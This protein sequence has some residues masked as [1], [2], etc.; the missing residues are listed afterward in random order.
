MACLLENSTCVP[1]YALARIYADTDLRNYTPA[2]PFG[3]KMACN[4]AIQPQYAD[5]VT[6]STLVNRYGIS[7]QRIHQIIRS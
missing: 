4:E 1:L 6:M 7:V 2:D 5:D 3:N